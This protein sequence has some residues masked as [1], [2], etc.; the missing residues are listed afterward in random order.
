LFAPQYS[1]Y[2]TKLQNVFRFR[3]RS[4]LKSQCAE[5]AEEIV[6]SESEC[7]GT[8]GTVGSGYQPVPLILAPLRPLLEVRGVYDKEK[9]D[10]TCETR[11]EDRLSLRGCG[12]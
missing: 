7:C 11:I 3:A 6:V 8:S 5:M 4:G 12:S 2:P 1:Q 10:L 9:A